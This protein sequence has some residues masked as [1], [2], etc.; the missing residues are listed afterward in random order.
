MCKSFNIEL[1]IGWRRNRGKDDTAMLFF[2]NNRAV[3]HPGTRCERKNQTPDKEYEAP[4]LKETI[5]PVSVVR[6]ALG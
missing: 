1:P 3:G 4:R 2:E 5:H 6:V